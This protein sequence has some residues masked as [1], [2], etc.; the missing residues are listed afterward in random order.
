[1]NRII[2]IGNGFDLAHG[3]KTSYHDFITYIWEKKIDY[4]IESQSFN[5]P[6]N[7]VEFIIPSHTYGFYKFHELGGLSYEKFKEYIKDPYRIK[8]KFN[9][10]FLEHITESCC[11]NNWVDV[12]KEY[13]NLLK[14]SFGSSS[15]INIE[16][17]NKDFTCIKRYLKEYLLTLNIN[18]DLRKN[19]ISSNVFEDFKIKDFS[20]LFLNDFVNRI[21]D[22]T[23]TLGFGPPPIDD[24]NRKIKDYFREFPYLRN[25]KGVLELLNHNNASD[26]Y[27]SMIPK[28]ILL[29][30]FNY[31]DTS[32]IYKEDGNGNINLKELHI[33]GEIKNDNNPMIFGFGDEIDDFYQ[34]IEN[35]DDNKYLE[36]IKSTRYHETDNYRLLLE[37]INSSPFQIFIFGHS[38]G[39]SDRTLL[40]TIFE[41]KNCISI[42]PFY[43]LIKK[44][45]DN[46]S[47]IVRN[48]SRHFKDKASLRDKV[49]NKTYCTQLC[50]SNV[51]EPVENS[52]F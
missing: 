30:N 20:Q 25:K 22:W 51:N 45:E 16:Q 4:I 17:L 44:G 47:N 15:N 8:I 9:N 29:L 28:D 18:K 41:H 7:D 40:N 12:E 27:S 23:N 33:H 14:K 21:L 2:L 24:P 13:Y 31:T 42:K 5:D 19:E 10:K 52:A 35:L 1:M 34:E 43:Y 26:Y 48:I 36:N 50:E 6:D 3:L 49:V 11:L 46:Y 37:F 38:C 39:L 32:D